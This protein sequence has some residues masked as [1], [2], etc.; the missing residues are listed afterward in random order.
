MGIFWPLF[1]AQQTLDLGLF[2]Y[3]HFAKARP[4]AYVA[5]ERTAASADFANMYPVTPG[6]RPSPLAQARE[7]LFGNPLARL[8]SW[9]FRKGWEL[10]RG[11]RK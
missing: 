11:A 5:D 3:S 8:V 10:L 6:P 9:P 1:I 2:A 4:I 7:A